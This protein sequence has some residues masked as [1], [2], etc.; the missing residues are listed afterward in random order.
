MPDRDYHVGRRDDFSQKPDE[1]R[2]QD[3]WRPDV[4]VL[5][6]DALTKLLHGASLSEGE[7]NRSLSLP[8]IASVRLRH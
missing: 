7:Y 5:M 6:A 2:R 1:K 8:N 4:G 3:F